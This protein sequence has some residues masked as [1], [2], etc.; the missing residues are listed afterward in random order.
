MADSWDV[1]R[2]DPRTLAVQERLPVAA[3]PKD[4]LPYRGE[5]WVHDELG[6]RVVPLATP[7]GAGFLLENQNA[8]VSG[9]GNWLAISGLDRV[10]SFS[11][12]GKVTRY[13]DGD[14]VTAVCVTRTGK[15]FVG[16]TGQITLLSK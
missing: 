3:G 6:H 9:N 8:Q 2:L 7:T 16:T 1:L 13:P 12:A 10:S 15:V 11:A 5:V 14:D 4:L